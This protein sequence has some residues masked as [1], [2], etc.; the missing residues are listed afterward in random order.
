M[1][2]TRLNISRIAIA[3]SLSF[4]ALAQTPRAPSAAALWQ[5]RGNVGSLNLLY[6]PGGE[7]H[8]PTGKFTFVKEDM[9]GTAA[10]FEV[11]FAKSY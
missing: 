11:W 8:Q 7:A 1:N 3:L 4:P 10:K 2:Q 9:Q 6:G 5:D